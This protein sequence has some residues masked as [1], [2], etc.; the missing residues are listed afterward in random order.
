MERRVEYFKVAKMIENKYSEV[1]KIRK[2][3]SKNLSGF[4]QCFSDFLTFSELLE[5]FPSIFTAFQ[6]FRSGFLQPPFTFGFELFRLAYRCQ[7]QSRYS[8]NGVFFFIGE[9]SR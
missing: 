3:G 6:I 1:G 7:A 5:N 8:Y 4:F 9:F 2:I